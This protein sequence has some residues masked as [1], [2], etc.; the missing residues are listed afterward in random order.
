MREDMGALPGIHRELVHDDRREEALQRAGRGHKLEGQD[1]EEAV[2][3]L[4]QQGKVRGK[5]H[6]DRQRQGRI[7]IEKGPRIYR[8]PTVP[9]CTILYQTLQNP[10]IF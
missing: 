3:R 10:K 6:I 5:G 9:Y 1:D 4:P 2:L 7:G 8:D